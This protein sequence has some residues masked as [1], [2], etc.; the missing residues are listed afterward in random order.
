MIITA[1]VEYDNNRILGEQ[2]GCQNKQW[3]IGRPCR[4]VI[5]EM[6]TQRGRNPPLTS[7][8]DGAQGFDS[9]EGE[10]RV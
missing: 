2:H 10:G 7:D 4:Y 8:S 5:N 6:I 3:N 1:A 9:G